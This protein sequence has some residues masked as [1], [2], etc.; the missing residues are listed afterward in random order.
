VVKFQNAFTGVLGGVGNTHRRTTIWYRNAVA[1][2]LPRT[3]S[4]HYTG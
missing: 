1:A 4:C 2:R 3:V